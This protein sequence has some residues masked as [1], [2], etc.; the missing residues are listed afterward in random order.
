MCHN[1][2]QTKLT[3][4]VLCSKVINRTHPRSSN[5]IFVRILFNQLDKLFHIIDRQTLV[6]LQHKC[7]THHH[8][9]RREA[10]VRLIA[11]GT[12]KRW[13]DHDRHGGRIE[14]ITVWLLTGDVGAGYSRG[15]TRLIFDHHICAKLLTQRCSDCSARHIT[16]TTGR[17]RHNKL[18][19]LLWVICDRLRLSERTRKHQ[20]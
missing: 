20:A 14:R 16:D 11:H 13:I 5:R 7:R 15:R 10:L 2:L 9:K 18:H 17:I 4:K 8:G 3:N 1:H 6:D 19:W 12:L